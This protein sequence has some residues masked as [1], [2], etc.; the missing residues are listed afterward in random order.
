MTEY[1]LG[2]R[3]AESRLSLGPEFLQDC[4]GMVWG[5]S[6]GA[7]TR[8]SW[9]D[10]GFYNRLKTEFIRQGWGLREFERVMED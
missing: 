4:I 9:F 1:M 6:V 5:M 2:Y 3:E 7:D 10:L 8:W